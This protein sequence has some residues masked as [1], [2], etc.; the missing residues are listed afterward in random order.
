MQKY[1]VVTRIRYRTQGN[2]V[3]F[4]KEERIFISLITNIDNQIDATITVY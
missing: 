1:S 3:R 2:V 4:P